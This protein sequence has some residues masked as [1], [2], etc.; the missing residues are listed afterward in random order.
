MQLLLV[1]HG[2][3]HYPTDSLT[4]RGHAEA[5]RL[6]EVLDDVPIDVLYA[7]TMGRAR[8]TAAYTARRRE[9]EPILCDWL[10]E[11]DGRYGPEPD[12]ED[13]LGLQP[14]AYEWHPTVLLRNGAVSYDRWPEE[15]PYGPWMEPQC[16]R[17]WAGFD[18][19]LASEGYARDGLCYRVEHRSTRTLAFFCH[20]GVI[21]ALLAHLLYLP[22][23]VSL[24]LLQHDT[25]GFTLL[26]SMESEGRAAFRMLFLN[27]VAHKDLYRLARHP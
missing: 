18:G 9:L 14:S 15:V 2:D 27:S 23:P 8:Q 1:R 5:Q 21:A 3:P 13:P 26:R 10:R 25:T 17:L 19:A 20:G 6:A 24:A 11:L 22:L 12:P 16:R 4:E 7:S